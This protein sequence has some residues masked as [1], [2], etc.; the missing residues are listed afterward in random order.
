MDYSE[1]DARSW[2]EGVR[3]VRGGRTRG[4]RRGD[5]RGVVELLGRAGVFGEGEGKAEGEFGVDVDGMIGM[6]GMSAVDY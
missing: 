4:V 1:R 2:Y 6:I 5:V 3:F